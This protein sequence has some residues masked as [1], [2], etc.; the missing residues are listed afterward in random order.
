MQLKSQFEYE[1]VTGSIPP[2]G[3][4]PSVREVAKVL[5]TSPATV[6]RAYRELEAAGLV[7]SHPGAG[8]FVLSINEDQAGPHS[9]I[10]RRAA[11]LVEEAA[12]EGIS[13]DQVLQ[14]LLAEVAAMRART[15][16][17]SVLVVCKRD[18]R[19][20]ELAMHVRHA[21]LDLQVQVE[22]AT[23]EDVAADVDGWLPRLQ[24]VHH[25]ISLAFDLRELHALLAPHGIRV[26]PII[27]TLRQDVRERISQLRAGTRVGVLSRAADFI[28]GMIS[29]VVELNPAVAVAGA[30]TCDDDVGIQTLLAESECVVYGSLA[31]RS[32]DLYRPFAGETIELV[33]V[34]AE[35]WAERFRGMIQNQIGI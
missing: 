8:F 17:V 7:V 24:K 25:V 10:R 23:I 12:R 3:R 9:R 1:M 28:D 14:I 21:L 27:A 31:R 32:L 33:Y 11:E 29:A 4:L 5:G 6:A 26:L 35:K 22:T 16:H 30:A 19:L 18:G 2:G 20:D 13:L 15:A 34:P